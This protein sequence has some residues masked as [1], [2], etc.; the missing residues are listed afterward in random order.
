MFPPALAVGHPVIILARGLGSR[1]RPVASGLHKTLERVGDRPIL[2]WIL[3][4]LQTVCPPQIYLHLREPDPEAE[5]LA[6]AHPQPIEV[7]TGQ[8]TGYL[9]DVVDCAR[10]GDRFTVIE[11]DTI[12][13]PGSLAN[14]LI[15]AD[16]MGVSRDLCMGI[17]PAA[18]NPNGPAVVVD[19]RGLVQAVSWT[20]ASTGLVPLGAW[21]W[22]ARMLT[23]APAFAAGQ[24]TSIADFITWKIPR[25]ALVSTIAFPAGHNINTPEDLSHARVQANAWTTITERSIAA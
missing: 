17:A 15:L 25:G 16:Q 5:Q 21:H 14:F 2:E 10:Y 7:S 19:E 3:S 20:A 8:P 13:Y 1:L 4:E 12:T 9:P 24:S 6:A 23:D 18:A 22:T 11:A